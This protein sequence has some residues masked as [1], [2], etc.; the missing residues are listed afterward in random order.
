MRSESFIVPYFHWG[1]RRIKHTMFIGNITY[2]LHNL[3]VPIRTD[4]T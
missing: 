4:M 2:L 1:L 3:S